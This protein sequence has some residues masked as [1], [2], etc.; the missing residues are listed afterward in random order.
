MFTK[1]DIADMKPKE[2]KM[3][4]EALQQLFKRQEGVVAQKVK[5][6][7]NVLSNSLYNY[8]KMFLLSYDN[9]KIR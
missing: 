8:E 4:W 7:I 1:K 6:E 2:M 9:T 5:S 3:Y